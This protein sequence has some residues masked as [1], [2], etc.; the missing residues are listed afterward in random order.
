MNSTRE[1]WADA[2][3]ETWQEPRHR[4][5][6]R[7]VDRLPSGGHPSPGAARARA[8]GVPVRRRRS[9]RGPG[10]GDRAGAGMSATHTHGGHFG[11]GGAAP[12]V[13]RRAARL[14]RGEDCAGDLPDGEGIETGGAATTWGSA[15]GTPASR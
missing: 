8:H 1:L 14:R 9:A 6:A 2:L 5:L 15:N 7:A 4:L 3:C 10:R 12:G 11:V 13:V